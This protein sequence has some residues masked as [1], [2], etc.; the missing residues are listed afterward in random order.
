MKRVYSRITAIILVI[1]LL[2]ISGCAAK[3]SPKLKVAT[4]TSLIADIVKNV[5][6]DKVETVN[7]VPPAACPG[8]FDLKPGDVQKLAKARLF[9]RHDWQG[10]MFTKELI[11]SVHNRDL[12]VVE[13]AVAGNWMA[14]PVQKEAVTKIAG[15]LMEKDPSNMAYYKQ[16][17]DRLVSQIESKGK[18]TLSR[19]QA[20]GAGGVK[21][22]C[23]DMQQGFLK[24]AGFDVVATYGRPEE[25][26]PQKM[27]ELINKG[28]QAGVKL[29]VDNLQ[30]GPDAGKGI[31]KELGA[32]QVTIS[33]F[34]GGLPQTDT[35][36]AALDKNVELLLDALKEV[37]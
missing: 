14:P 19:L 1:L 17:A 35:W 31:A 22:L 25:L 13:V 37:K 20:A 36:S 28:K 30:S 32:V 33:N 12:Q 6:G 23:S 7:I 10:K 34:P 8:H 4:G 9:L 21:V 15:I 26:N 29:V 3:E 11:E 5:G 16:N 18:E 2:A 24:W 27:Q